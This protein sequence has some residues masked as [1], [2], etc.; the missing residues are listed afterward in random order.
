MAPMHATIW[1]VTQ[2]P[3]C[4]VVPLNN[5]SASGRRD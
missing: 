3:R 1:A 2:M 4:V 5:R